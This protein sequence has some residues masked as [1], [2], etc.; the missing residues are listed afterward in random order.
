MWSLDIKLGGTNNLCAI[1]GMENIKYLELWQIRELSDIEVVSS[2]VGLQFLFLQSL[3][4]VTALPSLNRLGK[5]RRIYLENMSG[6]ED[7]SSL[8][9]A[10]A[11]KEFIH[12]SAHNMQPGDYIPLFRNPNLKRAIVGFGSDKKNNLFQELMRE[13]NIEPLHSFREF[14]FV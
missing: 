8:E 14:E 5:L 10:A 2:L 6:L 7:V 11:L 4:R 12:V 1:E 3:R 9:Y 13:H